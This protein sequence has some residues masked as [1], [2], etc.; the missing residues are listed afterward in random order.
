[1]GQLWFKNDFIECHSPIADLGRPS[2]RD[3]RQML[4]ADISDDPKV[5]A[6]E[7]H[8]LGVLK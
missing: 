6:R 3:A 1:M 5:P 4:Q 2:L 8:P 7:F